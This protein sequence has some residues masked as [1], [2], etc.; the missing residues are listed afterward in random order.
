MP[1][2][3]FW[4]RD[5][6]RL[7]R[8]SVWCQPCLADVEDEGTIPVSVMLYIMTDVVSA[9]PEIMI[10]MGWPPPQRC[11]YIAWVG[12]AS[13]QGSHVKQQT[14]LYHRW[15]GGKAACPVG[16]QGQD[17]GQL[18]LA[19][20]QTTVDEGIFFYFRRVKMLANGAGIMFMKVVPQTFAC[21]W[22]KNCLSPLV[23]RLKVFR[24]VNVYI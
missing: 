8:L 17:W 14:H 2:C 11:L 9:W 7:G 21:C 6:Y 3:R 23:I 24:K 16:H 5:V 12:S 19:L 1:Q 15:A 10:W 20:K 22:P 4:G 18:V 13:A